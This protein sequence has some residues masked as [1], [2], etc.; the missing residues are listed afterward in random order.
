[1]RA[2]FDQGRSNHEAHE[3][4]EG[5]F[6]RARHAVP[7]HFVSSAP[8]TAMSSFLRALRD[9]LRGKFCLLSFA[10]GFATLVL[11]AGSTTVLS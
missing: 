10:C 6:R 7:L 2:P 8:F 1:M 9:L 3:G 4:H 5:L 11:H